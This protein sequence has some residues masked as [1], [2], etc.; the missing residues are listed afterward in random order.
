MVDMVRG[1]LRRSG[2]L[3]GADVHSGVIEGM[4]YGCRLSEV[5]TLCHASAS[6]QGLCVALREERA[7]VAEVYGESQE[8]ERLR[9]EQCAAA[10]GPPQPPQEPWPPCLVWPGLTTPRRATAGLILRQAQERR[11]R[12]LLLARPLGGQ[13]RR[14]PPCRSRRASGPPRPRPERLGTRPVPRSLR[15]TCLERRSRC[16][17]IGRRRG[18]RPTRPRLSV[19]GGLNAAQWGRRWGRAGCCPSVRVP[20][21]TSGGTRAVP[22]GFPG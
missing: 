22:L 8:A 12:F 13:Q 10:A 4:V 1:A 18:G 21:R 14:V 2:L 6:L 11:G 19:I 3:E 20:T 16:T 5:L 15:G 17:A 7:H 9:L